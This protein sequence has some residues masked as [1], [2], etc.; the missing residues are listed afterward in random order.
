[1]EAHFMSTQTVRASSSPVV[2]APAVTALAPRLAAVGAL[3]HAKVQDTFTQA[4]TAAKPAPVLTRGMKGPSVKLM[5]DA[6]VKVHC[7][8][9]K[10]LATGP[11]IFGPHTESALKAFQGSHGLA[12]TGVYNA[13]TRSALAKAVAQHAAAPKPAAPAHPA[14]ASGAP[15]ADY[16]Q[17][18]FRGVTM[19]VRTKAMLLK[20]EAIAHKMG[21]PVPFQISQ[22]SYSHSVSASAG[23]HNGGGAL[24]IRDVMYGRSTQLKMVKALRMAGFAGW[25]RGHGDGMPQ[26]IHA[27]AIGDKQ[28]S[29][30]ARAQVTDY[31]NGRNGLA[32]HG[33][34]GDAAVGRP[35]PAW[36]AAY[37]H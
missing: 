33:K 14:P 13:A 27:I 30:A 5:Q 12:R 35:Y 36:A 34:D 23:T 22:G 20:A 31:F 37:H 10:D 21:V 25:S 19:N 1:L 16:R 18:H 8:S 7:L 3:P 9:A 17:V 29:S 11:G 15:P 6:L 28:M 24:D 32:N 26:H 4:F 2:A